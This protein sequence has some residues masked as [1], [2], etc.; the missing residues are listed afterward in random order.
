M[1]PRTPLTVGALAAIIIGVL[2]AL[3]AFRAPVP[4]AS[5]TPANS[6]SPVPSAASVSNAPSVGLATPATARPSPVEHAPRLVLSVPY[7]SSVEVLGAT[8][9]RVGGLSPV[10]A[11]TFAVDEQERV[12]VWDRARL[13]VVVY[14]TGKFVRAI[15]LPYVEPDARSLLVHG[16]R[17]YLRFT[18]GFSGSMEYEIDVATGGLLAAVRLGS[19]LYPRSRAVDV[20][21]GLPPNGQVTDAFNN[22]YALDV[23]APAQRYVRVHASGATLAYAVEP[24]AQKAIDMYAR[25]DGALYELASDSGGVGS[26]YVYALMP[27][28]GA[29]PAPAVAGASTAP[30]ALGGRS[31]PDQVVATLA[32]AGSV[33]LVAAARA[34]FWWLASTGVENANVGP[35]GPNGARFEA[36]WSDG[37]RLSI[38]SDGA[39]ISDGSKSYLTPTRVWGQ[40]AGYALASPSRVVMLTVSANATVRSAD[41]AGTEHVL[42]QTELAA[43][44]ASLAT[45]FSVSEG[46]LPGDLELAFP[47]YEITVGET[48]VQLR[49]DRYAAVSRFGAFAHDGALYDLVRR[50]L[51]VPA[52]SADDPRSLFLAERVT[53]EED[54]LPSMTGDITRWRASLVRALTG[55]EP[56][57]N[58]YPNTGPLTL[59]FVFAGGRSERVRV[60]ADAYTYR[61]T[62]Y[63]RPGIIGIVGYRGVP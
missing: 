3:G 2:V 58:P 17:L 23:S 41:L 40:L 24:L 61:G 1:K 60:T 12:Y 63:P 62:S 51:P 36:R 38:S 30:L 37:S 15:S 25:A 48:V 55:I 45:A 16:D 44:R 26:A 50:A 52:F 27:P 43:F 20:R 6:P 11:T 8:T 35:T 31:V 9:G 7:A 57:S 21:V 5:P 46:E 39:S 4:V 56:V 42:T 22:S 18:S 32:R 10:G 49:R 53:I 29:V 54:G 47:V 13:R 34:A 19:S 28:I 33:E 59:T 14:Q